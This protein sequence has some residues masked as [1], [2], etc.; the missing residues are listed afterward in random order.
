MLKTL[1]LIVVFFFSL[2]AVAGC[3]G[4]VSAEGKVLDQSGKPIKGARVVLISQ[5]RRDERIS[6]E[7]GSYDVGV[8]HASVTPSGTLT[9][10]KEG[11][12]TLQQTFTSRAQLSHHHDIVLRALPSSSIEAKQ[13]SP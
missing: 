9:I 5:G 1:G 7:D 11:Y 2:I 12:E 4:G 8:I 3:D 10:S 13:D 6:R